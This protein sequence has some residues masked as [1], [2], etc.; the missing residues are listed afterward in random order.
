VK[1][2]ENEPE[3]GS[4]CSV[5]FD[6][7]LEESA[8]L[9]KKIGDSKVTTSLLMSPMKSHEQLEAI[10]KVIKRKYGVD[11]IK[12]D[13]RKKGGTQAQQEF[14]KENQLYRQDYCGCIYGIWQQKN[15]QEIIDEL[16][17]PYPFQIL[18]SSIEEKLQIY[19]KR[20]EL[21]E[22]N[23][24]YKIIKESFL[25]YR[26]LNAKVEV[27]K[28]VIDSYTLF[29]SHLKRPQRVRIEFEKEGVAF[30]NRAEIIFI[31]LDKLN[32]ILDKNYKNIKELYSNPLNIEEELLIRDKITHSYSLS[33]IIILEEFE[34]V[35]YDVD[36]NSKI[37][38]DNREFLIK[39]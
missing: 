34:D 5:C 21:E 18:P 29:Y 23:V 15:N 11:F 4:R 39:F 13:Y 6:Y 10:G 28:R 19:Q 8:R 1:G 17:S 26:L 24:Q 36:I 27:K 14:A 37:Y 3:K 9:A 12:V 31:K 38:P 33:P 20:I 16:I 35:R 2:L 32:E 7:S 30:A 22:E 25:N